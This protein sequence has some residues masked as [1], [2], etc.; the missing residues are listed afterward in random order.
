MW[1]LVGA[2]FMFLQGWL[3]GVSLT[4]LL[5]RIAMAMMIANALFLV[6]RGNLALLKP[7]RRVGTEVFA[8]EPFAVR[9]V[10]ENKTEV[11]QW[12]LRLVDPTLHRPHSAF[13]ISLAPGECWDHEYQTILPQRGPFRWPQLRLMIS[14]PFGLME[15]VLSFPSADET[16]V[17]PQ[18]GH[19]NV[20]RLREYLRYRSQPQPRLDGP[21]QPQPQSGSQ[22]DFRGLREFREGDSP[23]WIH[24]KSTARANRV[25]IKEYEEPPADNLILI[26]EAFREEVA[27]T[28]KSPKSSPK[29]ETP[30]SVPPLEKAISLAAT[31]CWEWRSY[32]QTEMVLGVADK[33]STVKTGAAEQVGPYLQTL[34]QIQG[35]SKLD[36]PGLLT[37]LTDNVPPGAVVI[38]SPGASKTAT[39]VAQHLKR[40]VLVLDV[41]TRMSDEVFHLAQGA[42]S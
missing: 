33:V 41:T 27:E 37:G 2:G 34:A 16:L 35:G 23:R 38:V 4:M 8:Q 15:R 5:S 9:I 12:G 6:T 10:T 31:I 36:V 25:M 40:P 11:R 1:W 30:A 14:Y 39:A 17:L 3:G 18:L 29:H 42:L 7:K 19:L 26:L 22:A 21:A 24:W 32:A 13:H 28:T 20:F